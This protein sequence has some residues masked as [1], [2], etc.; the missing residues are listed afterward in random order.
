MESVAA[1][2]AVWFVIQLGLNI[3]Q[4]I[5]FKRNGCLGVSGFVALSVNFSGRD[6]GFHSEWERFFKS[7]L[8]QAGQQAGG[9]SFLDVLTNTGSEFKER[10]ARTICLSKSI[11]FNSQRGELSVELQVSRLEQLDALKSSLDRQG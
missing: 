7:K 2:L 6:K 3:A 1:V 9:H 11:N 10:I 4:G 5:Y 8:I